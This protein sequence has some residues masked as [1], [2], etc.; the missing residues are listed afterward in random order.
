MLIIE[1]PSKKRNRVT[2]RGVQLDCIPRDSFLIYECARENSEKSEFLGRNVETTRAA[3]RWRWP[4][5]VDR[6]ELCNSANR[7][8]PLFSLSVKAHTVVVDCYS[9]R[10]KY[11]TY[12]VRNPATNEVTVARKTYVV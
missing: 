3:Q 1:Y 4:L 7:S 8:L 10:L 9:L 12:V 5:L 2:E 6:I 11:S